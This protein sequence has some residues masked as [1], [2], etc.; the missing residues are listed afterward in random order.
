MEKYT[1]DLV[2]LDQHK[3]NRRPLPKSGHKLRCSLPI[4]NIDI[5]LL[6]FMPQGKPEVK[7]KQGQ[8]AA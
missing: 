8:Q 3:D 4:G 6:K 2:D 7:D 1:L 5:Q